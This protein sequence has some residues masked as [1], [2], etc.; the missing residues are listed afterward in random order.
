MSNC[1]EF[2][3][4]KPKEECGVFGI[5][6]HPKA[7][8]LSYL[9]IRALQHRGQ[10]SAGIVSSDLTAFHTVSHAIAEMDPICNICY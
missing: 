3:D 2:S 5:F 1:G 10:E 7:A 9:G 8:E 4:D 6:G